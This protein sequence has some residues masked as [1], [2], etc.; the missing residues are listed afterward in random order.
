MQACAVSGLERLLCLID[1]LVLHEGCRG[2]HTRP[3]SHPA[4]IDSIQM[5]PLCGLRS[6]QQSR[7]Q[8]GPAQQAPLTAPCEEGS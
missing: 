4:D 6:T 2:T 1:G 8:L 7:W 3:L 5:K